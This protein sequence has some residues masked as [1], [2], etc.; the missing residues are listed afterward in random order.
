MFIHEV[1]NSALEEAWH[2]MPGHI[3]DKYPNKPLMLQADVERVFDAGQNS[4]LRNGNARRWL[5]YDDHNLPAA[6]IAAFYNKENNGLGRIGFFECVNDHAASKTVFDTAMH[7]LRSQGCHAAE[8]P[9]N[10][11]EKDRFWG[12]MTEGAD[13]KGLY[14][15]NFNPPYYKDLFTSYGFTAH[16]VIHTFKIRLDSI[17]VERLDRMARHAAS[18]GYSFHHFQWQQQDRMAHDLHAIYTKS[19]DAKNRISHISVEDV[20]HL[21]D[22]VKPLLQEKHCWL[23]YKQGNPA[24]FIL[25]LKEPAQFNSAVIMLKGFAFAT[26][27]SARMKGVEA[28]L[29]IALYHQLTSEGAAYE[30]YLS[31]INSKTAKMLSLIK[32]MGGVKDKTHETFIYTIN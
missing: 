20:R 17:P 16:E 12:L 6:R 23:A 21:L 5:L 4:L 32:K 31:G 24:G 13:T 14:L 1:N 30:L 19:F 22:A 28:G 3:Y 29:C 8:G 9:V 2:S 7:W 25:F 15:D 11:G 18:A 27:P 10:F 26:I